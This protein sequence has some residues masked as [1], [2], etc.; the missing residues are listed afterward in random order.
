MGHIA[1]IGGGIAGLSAGWQLA[2][3][4]FQVS[5]FERDSIGSATSRVAAGMLAPHAEVKF[6]EEQLMHLGQYSLNLYPEFLSQ[7]EQDLGHAPKLD[8]CGTLLVAVNRDD[9]E[10]LKRFYAFREELGIEVDWLTGTEAREKEPMLSPRVTAGIWLPE[11][12]Q[13]DN[14]QLLDD[15]KAILEK[16][17]EQIHEH[18][19]VQQ[20]FQNADKTW[21]VQ[22]ETGS[23]VFDHVVMATGPWQGLVEEAPA[24]GFRPVKGE[25]IALDQNN[26]DQLQ[27][28]VRTP[29]GYLVPKNDG[30]LLIGASSY[31]QGFDLGPTAGGIKDLLE[32]G[33]EVVP[34]TYDLNYHETQ[35]GLR[36][37]TKDNS[38]LIGSGQ[39]EGLYWAT[40]HYRHGFL[41]A[42][43]TAFTIKQITLGET[44]PQI[45]N[46]FSPERFFN[47][48]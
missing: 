39:A 23:G 15:L 4:G 29:R 48:E 24:Y 47:H 14:W 32:F 3:N 46:D 10:I 18:T 37:A 27:T 5:L 34:S 31:E 36:P 16:Q 21:T 38:P 26:V 30:P 11:D 22:W 25:I 35:V 40:G 17:G 1:I 43:V 42:P 8:N 6:E 19:Q 13:I 33:Y 9:L 2:R 7:L 28:M 12:S 41:L 44:L 20:V 45:V